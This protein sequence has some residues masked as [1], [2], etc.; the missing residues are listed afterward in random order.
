MLLA[1]NGFKFNLLT[2]GDVF[3]QSDVMGYFKKM[4]LAL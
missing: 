3:A 2:I 1:V 4:I